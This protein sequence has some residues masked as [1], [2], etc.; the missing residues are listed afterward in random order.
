MEVQSKEPLPSRLDIIVKTAENNVT[1]ANAILQWTAVA[2]GV[3]A[4]IVAMAGFVGFKTMSS[5]RAMA[6]RTA[7]LRQEYEERLRAIDELRAQYDAQL[8]SLSATFQRESQ[9]LIEAAY[10]FATASDAY[11]RGD[12]RRAIEYFSRAAALQ[13]TNAI[14][15]CRV[16]RSYTN[17]GEDDMAREYF[18]RALAVDK[19]CAA[20]LRGLAI[21][22]RYIDREKAIAYVSKALALQPDDYE[23]H[24]YLGLLLRDALRFEEAIDA[25][26]TALRIHARPETHFFLSLLYAQ[27]G[28]SNHA[29]LEILQ[30]ATALEEEESRDR[31]R[32]LW[33]ALIRLVQSVLRE[34]RLDERLLTDV[35]DNL[36]EQREAK[37]TATHL[38][39]V[40]DVLRIPDAGRAPLARLFQRAGLETSSAVEPPK[41]EIAKQ[42]DD[43]PSKASS[44]TSASPKALDTADEPGAPVASEPHHAD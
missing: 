32:P 30:A 2:L 41:L 5:L 43:G 26:R 31:V 34:K 36:R 20:A 37:A 35:I 38:Q 8:S 19:D 14:I 22:Y 16:G 4:F 42:P 40:A 12:H 24:D 39:F 6:S 10:N 3:V 15:L 25:H 23:T 21:S 17:L 27:A 29:E 28:K 13:P 7:E 18:Q 11:K 44:P 9:R 1:I 33:A